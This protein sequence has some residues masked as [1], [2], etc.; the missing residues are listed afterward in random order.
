MELTAHSRTSSPADNCEPPPSLFATRENSSGNGLGL[1][2]TLGDHLGLLAALGAVAQRESSGEVVFQ[3]INLAC[4]LLQADYCALFELT[5]GAEP[6]FVMRDGKGWKSSLDHIISLDDII[7]VNGHVNHAFDFGIMVDGLVPD[8]SSRLLRFM[9]LHDVSSGATAGIEGKDGLVAILGV[10]TRSKRQFLQSELDLLQITA[11]IIGS[12]LAAD[13]KAAEQARTA[14]LEAARLKSAF[15]AN[16][17]HEI[18]SPLNV[19]LGYSEL[20]AENLTEVGDESQLRYL[21]AVRRAGKRLLGTVDRIIAFA[22]LEC[23][24]FKVRPELVDAGAMVS[25]LIEEHRGTAE[26]KGLALLHL[27]EADDALVYFDPHCLETAISNPLLN[28][29]KFTQSGGVTVR[30]YRVDNGRL[31]LEIRDSGIG[32]EPAYAARIFEPFSQEDHGTSRRFEG[33][34]LGLALTRR[35]AE[36]NGAKVEVRSVKNRGTTVSLE[37]AGKQPELAGVGQ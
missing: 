37:F 15:L 24:E 11:N 36:L 25:R 14:G 13:R 10:Y 19:I 32:M 16:T 18:R 12:A 17:T 29:I 7:E 30:L 28:A 34:G 9:R 1:N 21:D 22:K 26:D 5:A 33:A 27:I 6:N 4:T 2:E 8:T 31:K 3:A 20:V 23:G 35:Y